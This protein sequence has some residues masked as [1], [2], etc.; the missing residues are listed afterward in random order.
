MLPSGYIVKFPYG[1]FMKKNELLGVG[2]RIKTIRGSMQQQEFA[3]LLSIGRTTLIRYEKNERL[4][5]IE[6]VVKLNLLFKVQPLWL[7]TGSGDDVGGEKLNR[8]E[9]ILLKNYRG[10]SK[11]SQSA[12][13]QLASDATST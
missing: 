12:I 11:A 13:C 4:P 6:F 5:D 3:S 8:E 9:T 10:C 2:E 7:L 1:F